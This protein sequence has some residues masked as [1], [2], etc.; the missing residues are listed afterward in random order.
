MGILTLVNG[1]EGRLLPVVEALS[2]LDLG[3][4]AGA[5]VADVARGAGRGRAAA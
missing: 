4:G 3:D 1:L 2:E 5:E